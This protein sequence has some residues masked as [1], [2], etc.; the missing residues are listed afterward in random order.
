MI[1]IGKVIASERIKHALSREELAEK[2]GIAAETLA[3]YER[4]NR[5]PKIETLK[6][7]AEIFG[8]SV[9]YF[10]NYV[11]ASETKNPP[12]EKSDEGHKRRIEFNVIKI[13]VISREM[14]A[15]CG[16]GVPA[17]NI[18][19]DN[20]EE[21]VP[22]V[23]SLFR[24]WNDMRPPYGIHSEGD[25]LESDGIQNGMTAIINPAEEPLNGGMAL[26]SI[27]ESLSIKHIFYLANGDVLLRSDKGEL[28]LTPQEQEDLQ[29]YVLGSVVTWIS[30]R[31]KVWTL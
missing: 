26:V 6:K 5:Q 12:S 17:M 10:L 28:R 30:G 7:M 20:T 2:L 11:E 18:T 31:P 29:F 13:P 14:T 8:V 24:A 16:N 4:G 23:R 21:I 27:S 1:P 9:D 22:C 25:C 19:E 3:R 15:C